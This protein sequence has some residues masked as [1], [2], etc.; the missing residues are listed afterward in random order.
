MWD[1]IVSVPDHYLSFYFI[2]QSK[3]ELMLTRPNRAIFLSLM[4]STGNTV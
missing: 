2:T 4:R 3:S 1:L